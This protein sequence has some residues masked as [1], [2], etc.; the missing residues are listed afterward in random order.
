M[1]SLSKVTPALQIVMPIYNEGESIGATL[2]AWYDELSPK[3][4]VEFVACEDGSTDDTKHVADPA[5]PAAPRQ[6][7]HGRR[8]QGIFQGGDRRLHGDH[9]P[10]RLGGGLRRPV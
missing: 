5:L 4:R 6:A 3:V 8:P 10:I 9:R 7:A 2:H 1:A